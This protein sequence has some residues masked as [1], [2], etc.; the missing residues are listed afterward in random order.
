MYSIRDPEVQFLHLIKEIFTKWFSDVAY[1][2]TTFTEGCEFI[3]SGW[4]P[5]YFS[6]ILT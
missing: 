1:M 3:V 2:M 4:I 6:I 5:Q